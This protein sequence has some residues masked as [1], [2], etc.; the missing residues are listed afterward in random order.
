MKI[1]I[2]PIGLTGIKELS[3]N[4]ADI[5][6]V[7]NSSFANRLAHSFSIEE[8]TEANDLIKSLNKEI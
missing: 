8:I 3:S 1:A 7:G 4:G 6:L 2:T 5:F